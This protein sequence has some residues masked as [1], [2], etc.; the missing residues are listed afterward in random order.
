LLIGRIGSEGVAELLQDLDGGESIDQAIERFGITFRTFEAEV[1][2]Q[3]R[4]AP[5]SRR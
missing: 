4:G 1:A 2:R 3:F 5:G